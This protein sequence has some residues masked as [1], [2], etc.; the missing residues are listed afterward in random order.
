[1]IMT[2]NTVLRVCCALDK[3]ET[4]DRQ[5]QQ[6]RVLPSL[7]HPVWRPCWC[8]VACVQKVIVWSS[9]K[10]AQQC[11]HHGEA[12]H[13]SGTTA[14]LG[15]VIYFASFMTLKQHKYKNISI[16]SVCCTLNQLQNLSQNGGCSY[17]HFLFLEW[18]IDV[19]L[20]KN[21]YMY[22]KITKSKA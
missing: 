1:M 3:A 18:K 15:C 5:Q 8:L 19:I 6:L 11:E 7:Q 21:I 16:L 4:K 2:V 10:G 17:S 13:V 14:C 9:V 22:K 12:T 20:K